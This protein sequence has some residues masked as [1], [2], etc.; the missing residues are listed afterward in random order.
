MPPLR[1][2]SEGGVTEER[3]TA[4]LSV[5]RQ[6]GEGFV[7]CIVGVSWEVWPHAMYVIVV[8]RVERVG[9]AKRK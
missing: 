7:H 6:V 2:S 8:E 5:G 3:M 1:M 9:A 4:V